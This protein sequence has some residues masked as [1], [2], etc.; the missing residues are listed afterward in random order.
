M[1]RLTN[2][3]RAADARK[4]FEASPHFSQNNEDVVNLY[5]LVCD[6]LHLADTL[7]DEIGGRTAESTSTKGEYV[8]AMALYHY[9]AELEEEREE[10]EEL[11]DD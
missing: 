5:D 7:E 9:R 2:A 4:A 11:A 1:S 10:L 8:A 6:L 3:E